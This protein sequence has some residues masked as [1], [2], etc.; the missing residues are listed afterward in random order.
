MA[1]VLTRI[2]LYALGLA[3]LGSSATLNDLSQ[4]DVQET[5]DCNMHYTVQQGDT[6]WDI[7]NNYG[8]SF[9]I[10][11]LLCWNPE[12]NTSCTNLIAGRS[13]CVGVKGAGPKC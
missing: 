2:L 8:Y 5:T 1:S 6:C 7:C 13:I 10:N 3:T 11:Q 4:R 12:I 9:T